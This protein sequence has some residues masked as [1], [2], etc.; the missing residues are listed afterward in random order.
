MCQWVLQ[1]VQWTT[2]SVLRP[3][4]KKTLLTGWKTWKPHYYPEVLLAEILFYSIRN[5]GFKCLKTWT[6]WYASLSCVRPSSQMFPTSLNLREI[7]TLTHC[8]FYLLPG[9]ESQWTRFNVMW[10]QLLLNMKSSVH[11]CAW[12]MSD[13]HQQRWLL[14]GLFITREASSTAASHNAVSC[15]E[16][17]YS[18]VDRWEW[19][20]I[21]FLFYPIS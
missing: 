3:P 17:C 16:C 20:L 18:Q 1:S 21:H 8:G 7:N 5:L 13:F 9:Q 12:V 4:I 10:I 19:S 14:N 2:S 11:I 15:E 6:L